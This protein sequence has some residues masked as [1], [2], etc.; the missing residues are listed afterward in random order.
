MEEMYIWDLFN[1][2]F[3]VDETH[4]LK[5]LK[6]YINLSFYLH[7]SA[8]IGILH[9]SV[10]DFPINKNYKTHI[11]KYFASPVGDSLNN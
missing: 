9:L 3:L 6:I 11:S 5:M 8:K 7:F 1:F 2:F 4:H 10:G